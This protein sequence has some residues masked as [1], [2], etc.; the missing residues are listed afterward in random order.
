[1]RRGLCESVSEKGSSTEIPPLN[2]VQ[3]IVMKDAGPEAAV[4]TAVQELDGIAPDVP[5]AVAP[6]GEH[7]PEAAVTDL[8]IPAGKE[9]YLLAFHDAVVPAIQHGDSELVHPDVAAVPKCL[10]VPHAQDLGPHVV[11]V[12]GQVI[13]DTV[14][15]VDAVMVM[16]GMAPAFLP[17]DFMAVGMTVVAMYMLPGSTDDGEEQRRNQKHSFHD[18][19]LLFGDKGKYRAKA[20]GSPNC[21]TEILILCVT[22]VV[23]VYGTRI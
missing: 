12:P 10:S 20:I 1:M 13:M 22:K 6:V 16:P 3:V 19:V 14:I 23:T 18:V 7:P 11:V 21:R 8:I 2:P 15:P 9:D 5:Q 4:D 17:V